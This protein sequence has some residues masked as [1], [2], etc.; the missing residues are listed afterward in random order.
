MELCSLLRAEI[1][2]ADLAGNMVL[3]DNLV[4]MVCFEGRELNRAR[5]AEP[6]SRS[7]EIGSHVSK[8]RKIVVDV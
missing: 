3:R 5:L 6:R 4:F 1:F 2:R 7:A 8:K